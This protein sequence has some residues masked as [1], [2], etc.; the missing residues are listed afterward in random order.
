MQPKTNARRR[1]A[2]ALAVGAF[3]AAASV[4][5]AQE[6]EPE[7]P[8][9]SG[10]YNINYRLGARDYFR[11]RQW[12]NLLAHTE[13]WAREEPDNWRARYYRGVAF[14]QLGDYAAAVGPLAE[15]RARNPAEQDAIDAED[16]RAFYELARYAEAEPPIRRLLARDPDN[17]DKLFLW[18]RLAYSILRQPHEPGSRAQ[19]EGFA[20]L[21]KFALSGE[22]DADYEVWVDY[23]R[24]A[25]RFMLRKKA[26]RALARVVNLRPR[27]NLESWRRLAALR[28]SL[29]DEEAALATYRA[30]LKYHPQDAT[31]LA[32]LGW[33]AH[34]DGDVEKARSY[35][36]RTL[37]APGQPQSA[38]A[39]ALTGLADMS[40]STRDAENKYREAIQLNPDLLRAWEGLLPIIHGKRPFPAA[41][42]KRWRSQY[43]RQKQLVAEK[44]KE[45]KR[46]FAEID[47]AL[48]EAEARAARRKEQ[49]REQKE[50]FRAQID[51]NRI[52]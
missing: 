49:K 9:A 36:E 34:L 50:R 12:Q 26:E 46:R 40:T 16:A 22:A 2:A 11:R 44:A 21:E 3:C 38:R 51:P 52:P 32:R 28:E 8:P 5:G 29:D 20:A 31:A 39:F 10:V 45:E 14:N 1:L 27:Q 17:P 19:K 4:V 35:L 18:R 15:A 33:R 30:L 41:E 23:A 48:V 25:D 47:A 37:N 13:K 24:L 6:T 7:T 42:A 43:L